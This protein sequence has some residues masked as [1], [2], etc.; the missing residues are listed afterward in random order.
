M[1]ALLRLLASVARAVAL[2]ILARQAMRALSQQGASPGRG[3][4]GPPS[5]RGP[6]NL[7]RMVQDPA[8]G[9][10]LPE[11]QALRVLHGG[12]PLFF[13]SEACRGKHLGTGA[14]E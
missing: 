1:N 4:P 12:A 7:G 6:K 8:C 13:C 11:G 9:V 10:Y 3:G 5:P 2:G 14:V